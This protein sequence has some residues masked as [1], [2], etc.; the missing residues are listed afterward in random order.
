MPFRGWYEEGLFCFSTFVVSSSDETLPSSFSFCVGLGEGDCSVDVVDGVTL[1]SSK[2][3][4]GGASAEAVTA[5][6]DASV[7][8]VGSDIALLSARTS[9]C[10]KRGKRESKQDFK[11][12]DFSADTFFFLFGG[13]PVPCPLSYFSRQHNEKAQNLDMKFLKRDTLLKKETKSA[14]QPYK[15]IENSI[16]NF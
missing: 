6:P 11:N 8:M 9:G 7:V 1:E 3:G 15:K 16:C 14:K 12:G 2:A 13:R 10:R 4:C 5:P